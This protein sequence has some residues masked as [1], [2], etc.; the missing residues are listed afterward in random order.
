MAHVK[1]S[2]IDFISTLLESNTKAATRGNILHGFYESGLIDRTMSRYP[3]LLKILG[4][5]CS[6]IPKELYQKVINHFT[7]LYNVMMEQ[8]W[9]PEDVKTKMSV[10]VKC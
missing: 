7:Y 6:S 10:D 9:I 4:T 3:V 8:G 5:C 1:A 2:R